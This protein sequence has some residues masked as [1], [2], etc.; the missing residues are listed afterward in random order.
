MRHEGWGM[1]DAFRRMNLAH[2][3]PSAPFTLS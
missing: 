2:P 3:M 1:R